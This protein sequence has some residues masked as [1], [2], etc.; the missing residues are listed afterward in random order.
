MNEDACDLVASNYDDLVYHFNDDEFDAEGVCFKVIRRWTVMDWCQKYTEG[1]KKGQYVTW[2]WDQ[3]IMIS[4]TND[5]YFTSTCEDTETCT[6]DSECESGYIELTMSAA[7][8]CTNASNLK[9]RYKIDYDNDGSFDIDSKNF[10]DP[11]ISGETANASGDYPVG[12]HRIVWQVWDQ[13]G[14]SATCDKEFTIKNCKKPTPICI[15]HVVVEMM[16]YRY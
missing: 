12:T 16:P 2:Y 14:N 5:P 10:S 7:D 4:E 6:Y 11:I 15:D 9:W 1:P 13:C 8:D 3:V